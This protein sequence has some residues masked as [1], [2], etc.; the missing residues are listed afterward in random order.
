MTPSRGYFLENLT[1]EY[2]SEHLVAKVSL[3]ELCPQLTLSETLHSLSP[4]SERDWQDRR[5]GLVMPPL[6]QPFI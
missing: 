1:C 6:R 3:Y 5:V 2:V 4:G